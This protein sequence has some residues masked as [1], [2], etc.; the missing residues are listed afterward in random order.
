M[1][2]DEKKEE[3]INIKNTGNIKDES[4]KEEE[5]DMLM[6]RESISS[7]YLSGLTNILN[8]GS[9]YESRNVA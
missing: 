5:E 8:L 3:I 7:L 6:P 4:E 9:T 2:K 1:E